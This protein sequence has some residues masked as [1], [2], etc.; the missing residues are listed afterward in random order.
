MR[1]NRTF[2][3]PVLLPGLLVLCLLLLSPHAN[4]QLS[5]GGTPKSFTET[6]DSRFGSVTMPALDVDALLAEDAEMSKDEP[7]RFGYGFEVN[8][9][10]DN[11]GSWTELPDGGKVWRLRIESPGAYSI[12]LIYDKYHLPA[13]AELFVY[14]EKRGDEAMTIGAFTAANNKEHQEFATAPVSGD[15]IV[16]EYYEPAEVEFPGEIVISRVVHAYRD[17]FSWDLAKSALGFGSSGSCNNNVMCPEGDDWAEQIRSVAMILT[18]GGSR[19]CT[20]SMINNV[21]QDGT[22]YFLTANHCLGGNNT[23]IF[24]FNYQSPNCTNI[25]GPTYMTVQGSSLKANYSTSDFALLELTETPPDSFEIYFNGWSAVDVESDSAVGIH[26]PAGD[27]KKIS[28]DYDTYTSRDYLNESSGTTHWRISNWED[29]TTEPGSSGS[30]LFNKNHQVIGQ[31][32]GGYASCSSITSD[33][34]G[35]FAMSWEGGGS[36]SNQLKFWLDPDNTGALVLDG[37]DPYAGVAISH[38]PLPD[39]KDSVN[40]YETVCLINGDTTL[41]ADSLLLFYQTDANPSWTSEQLTATGGVDEYHAYI[42]AQAPGTEVYYYLQAKSYSGSADTTDTY[43]FKVVDYA[44]SV[45]PTASVATGAANSTVWHELT[46]TNDG[47]YDDNYNLT[48]S[49]E[50]WTTKVYDATQTSEITETGILQSDESVTVYVSVDIPASN[51]GDDDFATLTVSSQAELALVQA[52]SVQTISAGQPVSVPFFE[53]FANTTVDAALWVDWSGLTIDDVGLAEPSGPYSARFNGDP[54]GGDVLLS[55]AVDLSAESGV[56]ISYAYQQTGG[57]ESPD[58]GDDFKVE[59]LNDAAQWITLASYPGS[60]DD[61]T[62][63]ES[64]TFPMPLDGYHSGF[65][66]RFSNVATAGAFDDWFIDDIRIDYGG[67]ISVSPSSFFVNLAK[68][69]STE[70]ELVVANAGPGGISY[71]AA[72]VPQA[73]SLFQELLARGEVMSPYGGFEDDEARFDEAKGMNSFAEGR[74]V[75][76]NAGGPDAYGYNWLD[77]DEPGGPTFDWIDVSGTGAEISSGIDDDNFIGPFSIGFEFPY[78]DSAYTEF[79]V[80]ANGYIG[81]GPTTDL[82]AHSNDHIPDAGTPNNLIAWCWDD[83]NPVEAGFSPSIYLDAT[84]ERCVIQFVDYPEYGANSGDVVNAELILYPNGAIKIQY[85]SFGSGFDLTSATVGIEDS[86]GQDGLE[87][88]YNTTYLHD[89]LALQF[90]RPLHWLFMS[91]DQGEL[92]AGEEDTLM[93]KYV[94]TDLDSGAYYAEVRV[95]SNDPDPEDNPMIVDV[96]LTVGDSGPTYIC[97]DV[98]DDELINISDA[99]FV[100]SYI[101]NSGTAPDPI[102]SGDVDCNGLTNITDAVYLI[103]FIF[104]DGPA[105]C[106]ECP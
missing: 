10:L 38:T 74:V 18:S 8:Y 86:E 15:V 33:W 12:N 84:S 30:P 1:V 9:R 47:V 63:Y 83:L 104:G 32:H 65:R 45:D 73:K 105:P 23:W 42:P 59:Y 35:K 36:S 51:Y 102:E 27:I 41:V 87:V 92:A 101:F 75:D 57:G 20:G 13:G 24:M 64:A 49:G 55:Q 97:G 52:V 5:K 43:S 16:V 66:L 88:A 95:Y 14:N 37:Y 46:V 2:K 62:T 60:G 44:M 28:F 34:Y 40:A 6:L 78:Y 70:Q 17:L 71:T 89:N 80:S 79:Y 31:L 103:A 56:N 50:T 53:P 48:L 98:D 77:S 54:S 29:G 61:M 67:A 11:S 99:V 100:I 19:I 106:A 21:R 81:F 94:T 68:G 3:L 4:A 96:E 39:T 76:K 69:D 93:L 26:H 58:G 22:P 90:S 7:F 72:V 91:Y 82:G 25:D 85:Q